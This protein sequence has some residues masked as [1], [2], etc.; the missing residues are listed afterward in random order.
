LIGDHGSKGPKGNAINNRKKNTAARL[1]NT[2]LL[3]IFTVLLPLPDR[4][5][6]SDSAS[7]AAF[8]QY[9]QQSLAST[10]KYVDDNV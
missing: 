8:C 2:F 4:G 3:G 5:L 1:M 10:K 9:D 7:A 6:P